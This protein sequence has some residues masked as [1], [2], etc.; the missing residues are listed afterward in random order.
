MLQPR[1]QQVSTTPSSPSLNQVPTR[2]R[3]LV[4]QS[5][6]MSKRLALLGIQLRNVESP[7]LAQEIVKEPVLMLLA[8][9][10][11]RVLDYIFSILSR[12]KD[13]SQELTLEDVNEIIQGL[14]GGPDITGNPTAI[15]F[16]VDA[17]VKEPEFTEMALS[18]AELW[19]AL[20]RLGPGNSDLYGPEFDGEPEHI[21]AANEQISAAN[22]HYQAQES[23]TDEEMTRLSEV[24]FNDDGGSPD[25]DSTALR[26]SIPILNQVQSADFD[27]DYST[28]TIKTEPSPP[29]G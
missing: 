23:Q 7:Q 24:I 27:E 19:D 18:R 13:D 15:P 12:C 9:F 17:T 28:S 21:S 2:T 5:N 1:P 25:D 11:D 29:D 22:E 20:S 6:A 4:Q 16:W 14:I 10:T 8:F 3:P 26:S